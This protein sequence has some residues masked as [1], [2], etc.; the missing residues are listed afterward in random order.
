MAFSGKYMIYTLGEKC[1][2]SFLLT[3]ALLGP[4]LWSS[5]QSFRRPEFDSWRYQI[6]CLAMGPERGPLSLVRINEEILE[7]KVAAVV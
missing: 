4:P 5:G 7:R 3:M 2:I 1:K 6:F